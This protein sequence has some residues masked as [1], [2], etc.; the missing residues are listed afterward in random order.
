MPTPTD[1][2]SCVGVLLTHV[3]AMQLSTSHRKETKLSRK[4]TLQILAVLSFRNQFLSKLL[5]LDF[6]LDFGSVGDHSAS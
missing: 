6:A 3:A 5:F 4:E 2:G 1:S